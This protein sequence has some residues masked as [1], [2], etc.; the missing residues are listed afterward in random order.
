MLT[1]RMVSMQD[2][3]STGKPADRGRLVRLG[4]RLSI[5]TAIWNVIEGGVAIAAGEL[6][7][8][9]AL[10]GFGIDSVIETAS[11]VVVGWRFSCEM[12]G[13]SEERAEAAEHRAAI[14]AGV[15]L[16]ALA[17]YLLFDSGRRILSLGPKPSTSLIGI[18]LTAT[19]LAVMAVLARVKLRT[20]ASLNSLALRTDSYETITCAWLS[21][22]TL[23][24]LLLNA[25][26]G[27]WWADPLAAVAL[28][29]LIV[30][31]ALEGLRGDE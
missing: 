24:G 7:G 3:A 27:W 15:M 8:S 4:L 31:E 14:I 18:A 30:R 19:A 16:L 9:V 20:A 11:A 12:S 22:T 10:L 26:F 17:A 2:S 13:Q 29:P 28:V 6:A 25:F 5:F 21:A 23:L 1:F